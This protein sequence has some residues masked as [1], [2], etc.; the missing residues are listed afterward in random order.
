MN[1]IYLII[2]QLVIFY[3]KYKNSNQFYH[4]DTCSKL[5]FRAQL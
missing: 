4:D 3:N 2:V 1:I 5:I